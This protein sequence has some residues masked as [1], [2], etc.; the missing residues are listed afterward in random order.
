MNRGYLK[1]VSYFG[2]VQH[3]NKSFYWYLLIFFSYHLNLSN[4]DILIHNKT[5]KLTAL[6]RT[7]T[8][9]ICWIFYKKYHVMMHLG[10]FI[11]LWVKWSVMCRWIQVPH[12]T[13][14]YIYVDS[15]ILMITINRTILFMIYRYSHTI[16]ISHTH[17]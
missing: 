2:S 3:L 4:Y 17:I 16:C 9:I 12:C 6:K 1:F 13:L 11:C 8:F 15:Y 5:I 10:S 14:K 7:S